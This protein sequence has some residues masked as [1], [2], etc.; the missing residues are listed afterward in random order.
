M[1]DPPRHPGIQPDGTG[2]GTCRGGPPGVP[3]WVKVSGLVVLVLV[4]ALV[5]TMFVVGGDHGPSRHPTG[6][7]PAEQIE[8]QI[9]GGEARGGPAALGRDR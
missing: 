5:V 1:I 7:Q 8:K 3:R 9:S 6:S 2:N 4:V